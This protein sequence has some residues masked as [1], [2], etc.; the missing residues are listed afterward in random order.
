MPQRTVYSLHA[1]SSCHSRPRVSRRTAR[2]AAAGDPQPDAGPQVA[3]PWGRAATARLG[4]HRRARWIPRRPARA[5]GGARDGPAVAADGAHAF[6][7][8]RARF[9]GA[10]RDLGCRGG[11]GHPDRDGKRVVHVG[12]GPRTSGA[13]GSHR[14]RRPAGA[15][16][17]AAARRIGQRRVL[18]PGGPHRGR[19][20]VSVAR[21]AGGRGTSLRAGRG[22]RAHARRH[23]G[24]EAER[25]ALAPVGRPGVP[26]REPAL[27]AAAGQGL[28][29][30][31][32]HAG[33]DPRGRSLRARPRHPRRARVRH[34]GA[35][36]VVVRRVPALRQR[37]R[38]VRDPADLGRVRPDLRPDPR[39]GLPLHR[40]VHRRDG[41]AVP[42][43]LLAHRRRR[44]E[45]RG[46]GRE[47]AYPRVQAAAP[48]RRQRGAAGLLQSTAVPDPDRSTASGWWAGTKS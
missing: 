41:G 29:R 47:P 35:R 3:R 18:S 40:P 9:R 15:R 27:S 23:G 6:A 48:L 43:S 24:G 44:G 2:R 46:V 14:G 39:I 13:G 19:A 36:H 8:A 12:C 33:P 30:P 20:T 42:R 32:L 26:R 38:A 34:A 37:H 1:F 10:P 7:R 16:D 28:G 17:A 5:G 22:D 25:A 11:A 31:V 4:F 45:R 21:T